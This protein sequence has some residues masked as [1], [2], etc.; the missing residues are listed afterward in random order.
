MKSLS[1]LLLFQL[2][3][4]VAE[5]I[6]AAP[7]PTTTLITGGFL[8]ANSAAKHF[9][10][11]AKAKSHAVK[12]MVMPELGKAKPKCVNLDLEKCA[13]EIW[14]QKVRD[15][16]ADIQNSEKTAVK[17][18][19][20][21]DWTVAKVEE[22]SEVWADPEIQTKL[23]EL[24]EK[25]DDE[26]GL[27]AIRSAPVPRGPESTI[28]LALWICAK[29]PGNMNQGIGLPT[30]KLLDKDNRHSLSE[31]FFGLRNF[32]IGDRDVHAAFT[33][34]SILHP[35]QPAFKADQ[36]ANAKNSGFQYP[37]ISGWSCLTAQA[38]ILRA[39]W[40]SESG[41]PLL[42][43]PRI[44]NR[45]VGP[46]RNNDDDQWDWWDD[47]YNTGF[48]GDPDDDNPNRR[49]QLAPI[50][51]KTELV[52]AVGDADNSLPEEIE[53]KVQREIKNEL[54]E[55]VKGGG[56]RS[57][58]ASYAKGAN[59]HFVDTVTAAPYDNLDH[60]VK[61]VR[62]PNF[63]DV[64]EIGSLKRLLQE[65][66][67]QSSLTTWDE[68][69]TTLKTNAQNEA[70]IAEVAIADTQF[71]GDMEC[72]HFDEFAVD[73]VIDE[74]K[75]PDE[76]LAEIET[77][78]DASLDKLRSI[79]PKTSP[80]A[81]AYMVGRLTAGEEEFPFLKTK[82]KPL[83]LSTKFDFDGDLKTA[84]RYFFMGHQPLNKIFYVGGIAA[85]VSAENLNDV[86][87][88]DVDPKNSLDLKTKG[89]AGAFFPALADRSAL[90]VHAGILHAFKNGAPNLPG[91]E[92][93]IL[94]T[95]RLDSAPDKR[96]A[97]PT[98]ENKNMWHQF[99][100]VDGKWTAKVQPK[101]TKG[102]TY[103]GV[104]IED[105]TNEA[106]L[107]KIEAV[108]VEDAP[109]RH[110]LPLGGPEGGSGENGGKTAE[111]LAA[112]AAAAEAEATATN[113][114]EDPASTKIIPKKG[115]EEAAAAAEEKQAA[116][117][118]KTAEE[119]PAAKA[120][121]LAESE[122]KAE[123]AKKELEIRKKEEAK[124]K[125]AA[126]A[127]K[128][129]EEAAVAKKKE[130][131]KT[132]N[133]TGSGSGTGP[134]T[135]LGSNNTTLFVGAGGGICL[136]L[137]LAIGGLVFAMSRRGGRGGGDDSDDSEE[138]GKED[139]DGTEVVEVQNRKTVRSKG[140]A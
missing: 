104:G 117:S 81:Y 118:E 131:Q 37:P 84:S 99:N 129:E 12:Q 13:E 24:Y 130:E 44:Y 45:D 101:I 114:T 107:A 82:P 35:G 63:N 137:C 124:Q 41:K 40:T 7:E 6:S 16:E 59:R 71:E 98:A 79:E 73:H 43:A 19:E 29:V 93:Y 122:E 20:R 96:I 70:K 74:G 135:A 111:E 30:S 65:G 10:A 123:A 75:A 3:G 55:R 11:Y 86:V 61:L 128:K 97:E 47:T 18:A 127:K 39:Q 28:G 60:H 22:Y 38:A 125:E 113:K 57:W 14:A 77:E 90:A 83:R 46:G 78:T 103:L 132:A 120:A 9:L 25:K 34:T 21:D 50:H 87:S 56:T 134:G 140:R 5:G 138:G 23:E 91:L 17:L 112:A 119:E 94:D 106:V 8:Q 133:K 67:D 53:T 58:I 121:N 102:D 62:S 108:D 66:S 110:P 15:E 54:V 36:K 115:E 27:A 26:E 33:V 49:I 1:L 139:S 31:A 72:K 51:D 126:E 64:K 42:V 85:T 32:F 88:L 116:A 76:K 136:C 80:F 52:L 92:I 109:A 48:L 2:V 95:G 68:D 100:P 4:A 89:K 105:A 69:I